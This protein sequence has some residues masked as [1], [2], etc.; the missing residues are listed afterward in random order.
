MKIVTGI[1]A[2]KDLDIAGGTL[3]GNLIAI[4]LF[5]QNFRTSIANMDTIIDVNSPGAPNILVSS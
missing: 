5:L 1:N 2:E 3:S 4:F